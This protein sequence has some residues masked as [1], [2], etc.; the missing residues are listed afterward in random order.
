MTIFQSV[1][2]L[3]EPRIIGR[4]KCNGWIPP[5]YHI[6][7]GRPMHENLEQ[8]FKQYLL[9]PK[10][11]SDQMMS[12]TSRLRDFI[13]FMIRVNQP[14]ST[15]TFQTRLKALQLAGS[16]CGTQQSLETAFNQATV[17][18]DRTSMKAIRAFDK[19]A[20]YQHISNRLSNLAGSSKFR[21][22]F[23]STRFTFLDSYTRHKVL[24]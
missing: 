4:F 1:V 9:K 16:V 19:I 14:G 15:V 8:V 21:R 12:L 18:V 23:Q 3:Y 5:A 17:E 13:D 10:K 2:Q 22:V 24:G 20:N 11:F 7:A 6:K